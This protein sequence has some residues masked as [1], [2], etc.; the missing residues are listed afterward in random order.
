MRRRSLR[1]SEG[2]T[3]VC[4]AHERDTNRSRAHP[5]DSREHL[6]GARIASN[7]VSAAQA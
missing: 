7:D 2:D 1:P 4:A 6:I 3:P 5:L